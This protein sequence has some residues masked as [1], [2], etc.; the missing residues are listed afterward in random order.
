MKKT[1]W[2]LFAWLNMISFTDIHAQPHQHQVLLFTKTEGFRHD[3]IE[4]GVEVMR[5]LF[6]ENGIQVSH[7]EDADVFLSDSLE[8]FHAVIFFSTTG[9]ILNQPQ[10][11]AFQE[12]LLSGNGFM[13]IHAATDTEYEWAWYGELI[14]GYFAS[15]PEVQQAEIHINDRDHPATRHL[16]DVWIHRDEWYDFKD[17]RSGLH[18]LMELDENTYQGGQMGEFHPI[19]WYQDFQGIRMF[20]TG[21]GHTRE[22]LYEPSFQKHILG[23]IQYVL[24]R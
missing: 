13:G 8:K 19:A 23:G 9:E 17:M 3:N 20:Y 6:A 5:T 12:F 24:A 14:G 22:S 15:H 1:I 10:K 16:Q 4:E 21:L 18:I 7:T 11:L 2:L